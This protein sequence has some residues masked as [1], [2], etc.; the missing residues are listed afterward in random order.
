MCHGCKYGKRDGPRKRLA[1]KVVCNESEAGGCSFWL[2]MWQAPIPDVAFLIECLEG[3]EL[4][5]DVPSQV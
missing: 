4:G 1:E 2:C 5:A 3:V